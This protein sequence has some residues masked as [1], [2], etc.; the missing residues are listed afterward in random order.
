LVGFP[1]QF[2]SSSAGGSY[3]LAGSRAVVVVDLWLYLVM[4]VFFHERFYSMIVLQHINI[5]S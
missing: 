4:A 5:D 2:G 1:L 3:Q